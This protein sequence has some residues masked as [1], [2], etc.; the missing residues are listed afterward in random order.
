MPAVKACGPENEIRIT[1]YDRYDI[2]EMTT[3]ELRTIIWRYFIGYWNNQRICSANGGLPQSV[4][5]CGQ[6]NTYHP[7]LLPAL[8]FALV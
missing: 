6:F 7:F 4:I 5:F 3:D 2:E 8:A 1:V